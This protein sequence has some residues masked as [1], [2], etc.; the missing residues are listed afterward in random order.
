VYDNGPFD[1]EQACLDDARDYLINSDDTVVVKI[2]KSRDAINVGEL[3]GD[4]KQLI[5]DRVQ[6]FDSRC[7]TS[8]GKHFEEKLRE[9][10]KDEVDCSFDF[11][12]SLEGHLSLMYNDH[13]NHLQ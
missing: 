12:I 1:T 2:G 3:V 6:E 9:L 8:F 5:T 7:E 13:G 11:H 10:L 4:I